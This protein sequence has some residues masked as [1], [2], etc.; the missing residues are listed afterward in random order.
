MKPLIADKFTKPLFL[1]WVMVLPQIVLALINFSSWRLVSGEMSPAQKRLA[2]LVFAFEAVILIAGILAITVFQYLKRSLNLIAC[3][4]LFLIHIAYLWIITAWLHKLLP[5]SV[6]TWILP[7]N[8]VLYY[9]Y[10]LMMPVI[11]Y[12][13]LRLSCFKLPVHRVIDVLI[14]VATLILVPLCSYL[15]LNVLN[16]FFWDLDIPTLI[17]TI[18]FIGATVITMMAFLRVLTFIYIWLNE[19]KA[20]H[21]FLLLAV[22]L[23]APLGG[24]VTNIAIPFPCDFQSV[25]VYVLAVINGLV[26]LI[27][28]RH[29][30]KKEAFA[31][32]VRC[33][34]YPFSLYFFLVFL[35]FLPLSLFAMIAFG[36][37]FLI[38]A[39]TALFIV[40]TRK[41]VDE[42]KR[43]ANLLG[44]KITLLLFVVAFAVIPAIITVEALL[45]R[46]ALMRAVDVVY[47]PDYQKAK[48]EIKPESVKR[49]LLKLRDKKDGIFLPF[50]SSF[51]NKVVFNGMVLP[52]HKMN[53]MYLMFCGEEMPKGESPVRFG[54]GRRLSFRGRPVRMPERNVEITDI[55]IEERQDGEFITADIQLALTNKGAGQSE[56]VSNI[57]LGQGVM[58]S[59]Y[60]LNVDGKKVNGHIFEKKAAMW[61]YHMIRDVTRRDPGLLIYKPGNLLKLSVFPFDKDQQRLTGIELI[62]PAAMDPFVK[63]GGRIL[64][65]SSNTDQKQEKILLIKTSQ[66]NTSVILPNK[67]LD[68]LPSVQR[69]P[70][71]HFI[72]DSSA[73]AEKS[74]NSF[75]KRMTQ[76]AADFGYA[77]QCRITLANYESFDITDGTVS[78]IEI[79]RIMKK[80]AE[81]SPN[82]KGAFC[83]ER[84]IKQKLLN[85]NSTA[86]TNVRNK[87]TVPVFVVI[88]AA[89]TKAVSISDMSSFERFVPDMGKYY[90]ASHDGKLLVNKFSDKESVESE[91]EI[92]IPVVLLGCGDST[93]VVVKKSGWAFVDFPGGDDVLKVYEPEDM[94]FTNIENFTVLN[95]DIVY[96]QGL[97]AWQKYRKTV[98]SPYTINDQLPDIVKMSG[99]C[100]VMTPVTSYIVLENTAQLEMLKRKEKQGLSSNQALDFDEFLESPAPSVIFLAPFVFALLFMNRWL[101][102]KRG[103]CQY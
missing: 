69:R 28:F 100:G 95:S 50:I 5:Q 60:W 85:F 84:A 23:I 9:Q 48:I 47:N 63:I 61:V 76:I 7:P 3:L 40:H 66:N 10:I 92:P 89:D 62:Y 49:S 39:P 71:L 30:S 93:P 67:I 98:Y 21:L 64:K 96:A 102:K 90:I 57:Q 16:S 97:A 54:L 4:F 43:V 58:V 22:G 29:G 13:G 87:L 68:T 42:G 51:Y 65:I 82:F 15:L 91:I 38:L 36:S 26:L 45:D 1:L 78:T 33:L 53:D 99:D 25:S 55:E 11:F 101:R 37:G 31:W 103:F 79:D 94:S 17:L 77:T 72:V 81:K 73:N 14:T 2:Y 46:H 74:F 32:V 70:Y 83:Y 27:A 6:T 34:M 86:L 88:M 52:D 35:P 19:F 41:I 8:E 18:L 75:G 59:G 56:F 24:L 80:A 44:P 20:G 12:T